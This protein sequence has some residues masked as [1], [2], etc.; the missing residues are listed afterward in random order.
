MNV[1]ILIILKYIRFLATSISWFFP[2]FVIFLVLLVNKKTNILSR[3]FTINF[4]VISLV[5]WKK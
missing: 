1:S 4:T 3:V 2:D 5:D